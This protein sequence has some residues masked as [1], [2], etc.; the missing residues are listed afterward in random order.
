MEIPPL[1]FDICLNLENLFLYWEKKAGSDDAIQQMMAREVL[2][3][4]APLWNFRQTSCSPA[5]LSQNPEA[6]EALLAPF[7]PDALSG[8]EIKAASLPFLPFFIYQSGKLQQL[9]KEAGPDFSISINGI[10]N[11]DLYRLACSR[12]LE[13]IYQVPVNLRYPM[14]VDIPDVTTGE[15]HHFKVMR[16][17]DYSV[18]RIKPDTPRLT[19]EDIDRLLDN[20]QDIALWKRLLPPCNYVYEGVHFLTFF[21]Q[22]EEV[23]LSELKRL[24]LQPQ[25]MQRHEIL[26]Q[27]EHQLSR[28]LHVGKLDIGFDAFDE[29]GCVIRA[30]HGVATSSKLLEDSF[31]S[32]VDEWYCD[33]AFDPLLKRNE[34]YA[35]SNRQDMLKS[36]SVFVRRMY[37]KGV[38]SFII[39]PLTHNDK[40]IAFIELTSAKEGMLNSVV[41]SKLKQVLP[42]FSM[43]VGRAMDTHQMHLESIIQD[44]YTSLHPTVTWK[45]LKAAESIFQEELTGKAGDTDIV[46]E[47]VYPLF[48]QFDIRGSS[49]KRNDAI[50]ADIAEQLELA[51]IV[52]DQAI[53]TFKLPIYQQLRF[54]VGKYIHSLEETLQA[55]DEI[56]IVDFMRQEIEPAFRFFNAQNA[57]KPA[58]DRYFSKLDQQLGVIYDRRKKY[59]Q[60]VNQ[61]N[62]RIAG[63]IRHQQTLAQQMFPH[64]F[65]QFKTDGVE[66]NAFIGQSL[67]QGKS[68]DPVHLKNLRLWQLLV[69][70]GV[71]NIH[72]TYKPSLPV[73]MDIA[74]LVLAYGHPLAIRFRQDERRFDVDGAYNVHYEILKKRIDKAYVKHKNE[75]LT[76]PGLLSI[77]FSH[78]REAE[79]YSQ[80]IQYLQS[81]GYLDTTIEEVQLED[82]QGAS[83]LQA[84]RVAFMYEHSPDELIREM[85]KEQV[86]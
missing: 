78:E 17:S 61:I 42:I 50:R 33:S 16:N 1:P 45:F 48:G 47:N 59:E 22:T 65:D 67:V 60:S 29:N 51:A 76:Q 69:V 52:L 58:A 14:N 28:F 36:G 4:A 27:V 85:M 18:I 12:I 73:P 74:S 44:K 77:V 82:M 55:G 75:R 31:E 84:F 9:I 40:I 70:C 2:R 63:Y 35:I 34:M 49:D 21:D 39:A 72:R 43:V 83:G 64:Y 54:R 15:I 24:L 81:C 7:F 46:F 30:L 25:A 66:Y 38:G 5:D 57:L 68:L 6:V 13:T 53:L 37:E 32:S 23:S 10:D 80:Y 86:L 71:E 8:R 26:D 62:E 79:E 11:D 41:A 3:V 56:R 20:S 19:P